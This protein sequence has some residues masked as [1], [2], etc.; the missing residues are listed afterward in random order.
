MRTLVDAAPALPAEL[1]GKRAAELEEDSSARRTVKAPPRGSPEEVDELRVERA[2]GSRS[3]RSEERGGRPSPC[4]HE[5]PSKTQGR[6]AGRG[7]AATR[8]GEDALLLRARPQP[9][10]VHP[11]A[12]CGE[13]TAALERGPR[14]G[15]EVGRARSRGELAGSCGP[16]RL[17]RSPGL[18][19]QHVQEQQRSW[20]KQEDEPAPLGD[21][22]AAGDGAAL[23]QRLALLQTVRPALL[24]TASAH[25]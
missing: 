18:L 8:Y 6:A 2:G 20:S 14:E 21:D 4:A 22:E 11:L 13:A 5:L 16:L 15:A 25:V 19:L 10:L 3:A 24:A 1:S 17:T 12:A 9:E 7:K 23:A